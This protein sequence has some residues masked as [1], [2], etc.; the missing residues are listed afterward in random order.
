MAPEEK[1]AVTG[2]TG[3]LGSLVAHHL[4]ELGVPQRLLVRDTSRAPRL[5]GAAA[6]SF[7]YADRTAS[8]KALE[9]IEVLFMVSAPESEHR[10]Q[11]HSTFIDAAVAAGVKHVVYTSFSAASTEA[12]FTLAREHYATEEYLRASPA[13]FTFLRDSFYL[14]FLPDLAGKDRV[15]RGPAGR[16]HFAPVARADVARTAARILAT[17]SEHASATYEMT[18]P[19]SLDMSDVAQILGTARG[20]NITFLDESIDQAYASRAG[21]GAPQWQLDAWVSTYTAIASNAMAKVSDHIEI[22]TGTAPMSFQDYLR[23]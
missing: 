11:L 18:G 20:E 8:I 15:I 5:P 9:G 13:R 3:A 4:A 2:S 10:M 6:R 19:Q 17:A 14:D 22:I 7:D 1:I 16:G 12:E 21:Y 23:R